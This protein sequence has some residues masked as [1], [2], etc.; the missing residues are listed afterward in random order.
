VASIRASLNIY[1]AANAYGK[2]PLT[3]IGY[4]IGVEALQPDGEGGY[5]L[6]YVGFITL[7]Q[8]KLTSG[9]GTIIANDAALPSSGTY[10][11]GTIINGYLID[12]RGKIKEKQ[13]ATIKA[14]PPLWGIFSAYTTGNDGC[15]LAQR[16]WE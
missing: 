5:T 14:S 16:Q 11:D 4:S 6:A 12:P 9:A 10:P 8:E 7:T 13:S 2:D 3:Y 15:T 1:L